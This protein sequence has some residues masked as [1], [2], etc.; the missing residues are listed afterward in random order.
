[1]NSIRKP[2]IVGVWHVKIGPGAANNPAF[3]ESVHVFAS[4]AEFKA[5]QDTIAETGKSGRWKHLWIGDPLSGGGRVDDFEL[6]Q[7]HVY[8]HGEG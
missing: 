5:F 4:E 1:V 2:W 3:V 6:A 7:D 8:F